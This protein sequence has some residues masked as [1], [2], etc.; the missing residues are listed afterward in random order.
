M[1]SV[2][3]LVII[4]G[5]KDGL[6]FV[7]NEQ[8]EFADI[9]E[10]IQYKLE[11]SHQQ[12]L[13]GPIVHVTVQLGERLI[14]DEQ[15]SQL[16]ELIGQNGN[17]IVRKI[18]GIYS[19]HRELIDKGVKVIKVVIRSGQMIEED[20]D[21]MLLGDVNPGATIGSTGN[22][23]I[24]GALRGM[25]HAGLD[26]DEKTIIAASYMK[27]TQ[28]RIAH[29]ISRSPDEWE[30]VQDTDSVMEFAYLKDG[31]MKIDKTSLIYKIRPDLSELR[32]D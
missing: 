11:K 10:E 17:L 3:D 2:K 30:G 22:L 19:P 7:L 1:G 20:R 16:R 24:M 4:K 27:P 31:V 32:E 21:I 6:V 23:Y 28:L 26:G 8:C 18:E 29:V 12:I 5:N 25:A 9:I 14:N 15:R 13:A